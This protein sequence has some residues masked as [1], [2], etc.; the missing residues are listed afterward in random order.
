M[1][2]TGNTGFI[3]E[4][5]GAKKSKSSQCLPLGAATR[6]RARLRVD[7]VRHSNFK[8]GVASRRQVENLI[9]RVVL[10]LFNLREQRVRGHQSAMRNCGDTQRERERKR[11]DRCDV[12]LADSP[13]V[14]GL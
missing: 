9:C 10:H 1:H 14:M 7:E 3:R 6:A 13:D 12:L 4:G 11:K 5:G 8:R 2:C